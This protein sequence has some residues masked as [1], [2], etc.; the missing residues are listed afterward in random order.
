MRTNLLPAEKVLVCQKSNVKFYDWLVRV[1]E[2]WGWVVG[3]VHMDFNLSFG[4]SCLL[5]KIKLKLVMAKK[6][7]NI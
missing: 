1:K 5:F 6:K 4:K 2:S 7:K 3:W